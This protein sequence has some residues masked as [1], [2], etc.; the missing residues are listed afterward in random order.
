M[1]RW[2]AG[3]KVLAADLNG[4]FPLITGLIP[5][6]NFISAGS[7]TAIATDVLA[8]FG[9]IVVP[10]NIKVNAISFRAI[11]YSSTQTIYLAIYSE[12]GQTKLVNASLSVTSAGTKTITLGAEVELNPGIY[13]IAWSKSA[14]AAIS[15]GVYLSSTPGGNVPLTASGKKVKEGTLVIT[16]GTLPATFNPTALTESTDKTLIVRLDN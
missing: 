11:S 13:Y 9:Q 16:G 1:K 10:F 14:A 15:F 8:Y 5:L 2:T 6:P 7:G 4:N 3:E 12:D